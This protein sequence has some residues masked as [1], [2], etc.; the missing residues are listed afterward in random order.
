MRGDVA[1]S[2]VR[3]RAIVKMVNDDVVKEAF[4]SKVVTLGYVEP[5]LPDEVFK[6]YPLSEYDYRLDS[7]Y[8]EYIV[9]N[10]EEV[11]SSQR[12]G[13]SIN[14][15][16]VDQF[17]ECIQLTSG[18]YELMTMCRR[19][20]DWV[21]YHM[22]KR[23]LMR[24]FVLNVILENSSL[25][26]SQPV[27]AAASIQNHEHKAKLKVAY[28]LSCNTPVDFMVSVYSSIYVNYFREYKYRLP[29]PKDIVNFIVNNMQ[30]YGGFI[31]LYTTDY[32]VF[33]LTTA[34]YLVEVEN[35]GQV[36]RVNVDDE[37]VLMGNQLG[38]G[39]LYEIT[40]LRV[41]ALRKLEIGLDMIELYSCN[42]SELLERAISG[43]RESVRL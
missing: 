42:T 2:V 28:I 41:D 7:T 12:P 29:E 27:E 35:E 36:V 17:G 22:N 40:D 43:L 24:Y 8:I 13:V 16:M 3:L 9:D 1:M 4:I 23:A 21:V 19:N 37:T 31:K 20:N 25:N 11:A 32:Y 14:K 18:E 6:Y 33:E 10:A 38:N 26:M 34:G 30:K 5:L 39:D 15:V